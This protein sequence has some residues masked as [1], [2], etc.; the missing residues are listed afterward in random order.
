MRI[1]LIGEYSNLH[2]SLK[3]GLESLGHSVVLVNSGDGFKNFKSDYSIKPTFTSNSIVSVFRNGLHKLFKID[4][5]KIEHGIRFY[6]HLK[7]LKGFD[8]V[9][10]INETPIQT[11]PILERFLLSQIFKNNKKTILLCCGVD[12]LIANYLLDKKERYSIVTPYFEDKS[13]ASEFQFILDYLKPSYK[14]THELVYKNI[15]GVI[16]SDMDYY[17]P[18]KNHPKFLG[19]IP[20]P[21]NL[22]RNLPLNTKGIVPISIFLGINRNSYLSKGISFFEKALQIMSTKYVEKVSI[23]IAENIPYEDYIK[24]YNNCHILLDQVYGFDQGYNALEAMAKGKVVFT[25]A[26]KEFLDYY[27]LQEDEVAINALPDV[28]YLVEK[29]SY[30]I[31]NPNKIEEIGLNARKFIEKEHDYRI[32]AKKYLETWNK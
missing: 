9:Q 18:L 29:L 8:V 19:M 24:K 3:A 2:N 1:L 4:S 22:E 30:L 25:G 5:S 21:I 32:I 7:H 27:N 17:L 26:E 20:N 14:K 6:F 15:A 11:I 28:D 10:L 12:Y 23:E 13:D 16:A 31:E